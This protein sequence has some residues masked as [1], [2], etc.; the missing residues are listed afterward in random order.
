[1][2]YPSKN[3]GTLDL[4]ADGQVDMI[5]AW[6]DMTLEQLGKGTLPNSIK[7]TQIKPELNGNLEYLAIPSKGKNKEAAKQ[8]LNF[9]VSE[10]GQNIFLNSMK[11]IPVIEASNL[12]QESLEMLN[13]FEIDAFR[14]YSI[15][16]LG[17]DLKKRWQEDIATLE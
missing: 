8:F 3:Q 15:G 17:N 11:A 7:I 12:S 6:A 10:K 1:V 13:G 2:Q 5:P 9:V 16:E 14:G 4:L